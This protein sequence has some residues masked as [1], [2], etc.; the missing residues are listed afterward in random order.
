MPYPPE[1]LL[2]G[3]WENSILTLPLSVILDLRQVRGV[4][5]FAGELY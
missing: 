3:L 1:K 4:T 2:P 5:T